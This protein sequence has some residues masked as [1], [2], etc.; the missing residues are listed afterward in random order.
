MHKVQ[1]RSG[2]AACVAAVLLL[3]AASS[4]F[5]QRSPAQAD[6]FAGIHADLASAAD[7]TLANALAERPWM[8]LKTTTQTNSA[9]APAQPGQNLEADRLRRVNAAVERV[10]Q[11]RPLIDPILHEERI[12]PE[13]VAVALVESGGQPAALSPKGARGLW[14]FMP[15][16]ARRYG[17][18]VSTGRDDRLDIAKSTRAAARYL[19]DLRQQFGDWQLALAAYNAG[20][21]AVQ[22]ATERMGPSGFS[23]IQ[24]VLPKETRDYV[25]A[26]LGAMRLFGGDSKALLRDV[27]SGNAQT[28]WFATADSGR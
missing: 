27:N 23:T 10:R 8:K 28:V 16:T 12:P 4:A 18:V 7:K 6:P 13:L 25:P 17:L 3:V 1:R 5:A 15:D 9:A 14:Q 2:F 19:R 24:S 20:E 22:S 26:V 11:L 21:R